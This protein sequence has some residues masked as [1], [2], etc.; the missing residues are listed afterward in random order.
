VQQ[1][2]PAALQMRDRRVQVGEALG[3]LG[4]HVQET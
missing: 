1:D 3:G 4:R 2:L